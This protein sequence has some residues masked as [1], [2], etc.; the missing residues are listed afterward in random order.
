[1]YLWYTRV[2]QQQQFHGITIY[3]VYYV[4]YVRLGVLLCSECVRTLGCCVY[5][6]SPGIVSLLLITAIKCEDHISHHHHQ[7]YTIESICC[8]ENGWFHFLYC[9]DL[10]GPP[11]T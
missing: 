3:L 4:M 10:L 11:W 9:L 6:Y 1:M 5:E 2:Q 7:K 8:C